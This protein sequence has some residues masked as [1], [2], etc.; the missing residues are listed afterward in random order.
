MSFIA[1]IVTLFADMRNSNIK[2]GGKTTKK[3]VNVKVL[4]LH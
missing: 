2:L 1:Y 3:R 4:M